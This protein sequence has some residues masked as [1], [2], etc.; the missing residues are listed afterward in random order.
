MRCLSLSVGLVLSVS[1]ATHAQAA[2]ADQQP[3]RHWGPARRRFPK[4][5]G[6]LW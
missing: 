6:W 5:Q 3:G 2:P 4:V 1:P